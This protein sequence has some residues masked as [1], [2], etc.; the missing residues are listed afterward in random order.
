LIMATE[1][2]NR[3]FSQDSGLLRVVRDIGVG[4]VERS[5]GLKRRIVRSAAGTGENTPRLM[6]GKAL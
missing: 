5:T 2:I 1:G 4:L 6:Q 3:L